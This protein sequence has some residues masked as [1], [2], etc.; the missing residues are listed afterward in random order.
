MVR[1]GARVHDN[2]PMTGQD[3]ARLSGAAEDTEHATPLRVLLVE[4]HASFRHALRAVF[5]LEQDLSV[6]AEV[7]DGTQAGAAAAEHHPDVAVV[8]LDLPGA[9]GIEALTDIRQAS[10]DTACVVLT[11]LQD[12]A[13]MGRAVEAGAAAI[14]HK[15]VDIEDLLQVIRRASTGM[16]LLSP[17]D[18][19]R[20]LQA[21]G[22]QRDQ[23]WQTALLEQKLT[24]RERE[25]LALLAHG[26]TNQS[27][28]RELVISPETVQTHV[29]NLMAKVDERSRLALVTTAIRLG[30]V[31]PPS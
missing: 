24:R 25:V 7:D 13:E 11:A 2:G 5:A 1:A 27:I 18:T 17:N 6:V 15:S 31:D 22:R 26:G 12:D 10:P 30:I 3:S 8:D 28:A 16:N 14:L 23:R 20:W 9:D 4:D 19:A 29:R 21:R